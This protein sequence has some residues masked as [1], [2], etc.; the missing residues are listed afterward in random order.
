[1]L[2]Q[3]HQKKLKINV[4]DHPFGRCAK[5]FGKTILRIYYYAHIPKTY[6]FLPADTHMYVCVSRSTKFSKRFG[7][8]TKF[9]I[10]RLI[11]LVYSS[12][13]SKVQT[14]SNISFQTQIPSLFNNVKQLS[15]GFCKKN[16]KNSISQFSSTPWKSRST[17]YSFSNQGSFIWY[18][19]KIFRKIKIS[20]PVKNYF[21]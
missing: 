6:H 17:G 18:V 15:S 5:V 13:V 21:P 2:V 20:Y 4:R 10:P 16:F 1:M 19:R 12:C 7:V 11:L 8:R 14:V 3:H 9:M